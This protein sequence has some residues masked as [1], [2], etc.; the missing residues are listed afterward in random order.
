MQVAQ[1]LGITLPGVK[2]SRK[3]KATPAQ[4]TK[5]VQAMESEPAQ[6]ASAQQTPGSQQAAMPIGKRQRQ[7][8]PRQPP[9]PGMLIA[10]MCTMP[11]LAALTAAEAMQW[12]TC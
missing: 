5:P 8:A 1:A 11:A 7:T 4:A 3:R 2:A 9:L 12:N 6:A 10:Y